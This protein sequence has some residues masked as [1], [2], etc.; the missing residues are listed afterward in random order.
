MAGFEVTLYGRFCVTP[1]GQGRTAANGARSGLVQGSNRPL[2]SCL[3]S[4]RRADIQADLEKQDR[5]KSW[6]RSGCC[7]DSSK[8][9]RQADRGG[10]PGAA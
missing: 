9:I 7:L 1:E 8:A 3:W 4:F 6:D 10:S 2:A 5:T